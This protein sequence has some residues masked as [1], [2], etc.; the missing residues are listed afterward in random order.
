[1]SVYRSGGEGKL[2]KKS[3]LE[4]AEWIRQGE[5]DR[6]KRELELAARVII[7]GVIP[8]LS[9]PRVKKAIQNAIVG[10]NPLHKQRSSLFYDLDEILDGSI[11]EAAGANSPLENCTWIDEKGQD[12]EIVFKENVDLDS[13]RLVLSSL[14]CLS[15]VDGDPVDTGASDWH[16]KANFS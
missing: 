2:P 4:R 12:W 10:D 6:E 11:K 14:A 9:K 16:I 7:V 1:M 8:Y 13:M 3:D 5:E 15:H